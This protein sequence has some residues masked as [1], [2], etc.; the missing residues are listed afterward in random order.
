MRAPTHTHDLDSAHIDDAPAD[1]AAD[2]AGFTLTLTNFE[3]PFDLLLSLI[4]RRKLD[5]TEVALAEVTDEFMSYISALYDR[6]TSE[7]LNQASDFLVTAATLL[8][9]KAARLLPRGTVET[10]EDLALLEARDLL[11]ARLLQYRAYRE[12]SAVLQTRFQR[13]AQ[14]FPRKVALEPQF[15]KVLPEL[16][17]DIGAQEFA[18]I[19]AVALSKSHFEDDA[20]EGERLSLGHLREPLTSIEAEERFLLSCLNDQREHTFAELVKGAGEFEIAVV[21]FLAVLEL[22]RRKSVQAVQADPLGEITLTL[23]EEPAPEVQTDQEV[24]HE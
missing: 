12:V 11:F 7:A 6:G 1:Q 18:Q 15:K 14:R 16:V 4:A 23:V 13:E 3:G 22:V 19:A 8:D 17:F 20:A 21:R 10:E 5:I 24:E 9:L 2:S